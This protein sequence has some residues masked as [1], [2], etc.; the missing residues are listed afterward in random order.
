MDDF[1]E[2]PKRMGCL[3]IPLTA[4]AGFIVVALF[5]AAVGVSASTSTIAGCF[6]GLAAV[7]SAE[8]ILNRGKGGRR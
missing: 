4:V 5:C 3:N 2:E 7:L 6:G 1:F 8:K